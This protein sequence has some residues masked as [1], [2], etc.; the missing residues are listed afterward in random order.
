MI[1]QKPI[2][3]NVSQG[4]TGRARMFHIEFLAHRREEFVYGGTMGHWVEVEGES[5]FTVFDVEAGRNY[6]RFLYIDGYNLWMVDISWGVPAYK[7]L[8][9]ENPSVKPLMHMRLMAMYGLTKSS[10]M[11]LDGRIR[12]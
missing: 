2:Q 6:P 10:A 1:I 3:F 12:L 9:E 11:I 7:P 8:L 4:L 5:Q